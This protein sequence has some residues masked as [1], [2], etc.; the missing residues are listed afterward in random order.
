MDALKLPTHRT[1][2]HGLQTDCATLDVDHCFDGWRGV[3]NLRDDKLHTRVTSKL[4]RLVVFTTATKEFVA[5]EPVSHVN[6]AISLL[7]RHIASADELGL[8]VLQPGE[9]MSAEMSIHVTAAS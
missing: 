7:D 8:Q 1:P 4:T 3:L 5:I 9:S 6:N 2:S